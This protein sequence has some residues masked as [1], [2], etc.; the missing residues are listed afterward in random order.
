ML[1][2]R[3]M[4]DHL[5]LRADQFSWDWLA[6]NLVISRWIAGPSQIITGLVDADQGWAEISAAGI[7]WASGISILI[8]RQNRLLSKLDKTPKNGINIDK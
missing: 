1:P 6:V 8:L 3:T 5:G 7:E 4:N 2:S